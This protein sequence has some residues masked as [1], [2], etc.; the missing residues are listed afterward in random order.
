MGGVRCASFLKHIS[1]PLPN[2]HFASD[3][4]AEKPLKASGVR[5][6]VP[7]SFSHTEGFWKY[8]IGGI[9]ETA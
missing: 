2:W 7:C 3:N 9:I 6:G 1:F 8:L 5:T 4:N